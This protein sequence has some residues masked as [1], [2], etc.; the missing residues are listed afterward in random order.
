VPEGRGIL[1]RLTV[2]EN[3]LLALDW[4]PL[5]R[6]KD[7]VV[8]AVFQKYPVLRSRQN[9]AA[10]ALSGGEQQLL[11]VSRARAIISQLDRHC[12]LLDEPS[13]GL[14]PRM[15]SEMYEDISELRDRDATVVL[16][17]QNVRAALAVADR[18]LLL[19]RGVI[20]ADGT[21]EEMAQDAR[22]RDA[23][24]PEVNANGGRS[25]S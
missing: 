10:S 21:P 22:I 8:E 14:S 3:I 13:L 2:R 12:L 19:E 23:Y 4:L 17:E 15:V 11:A 9:Q 7:E 16:V 24:L 25:A 5:P 18:V 1:G 20:T 6:D